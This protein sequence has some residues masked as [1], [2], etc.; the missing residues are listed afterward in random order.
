M[1]PGLLRA[2]SSLTYLAGVLLPFVDARAAELKWKGSFP[3]RMF[4][5]Q[6]K[7]FMMELLAGKITQQV[8]VTE[9]VLSGPEVAA[10]LQN[11][12]VPGPS[13]T[14]RGRS[15]SNSATPAISKKG[16]RISL[17]A[18]LN[19]EDS[20]LK[21]DDIQSSLKRS[22]SMSQSLMRKRSQRSMRLRRKQSSSAFAELSKAAPKTPA[23]Q[24]ELILKAIFV[25]ADEEQ[26]ELLTWDEFSQYL[27]D[28]A[29]TASTQLA[30]QDIQFFVPSKRHRFRVNCGCGTMTANG[31]L[32]TVHQANSSA[33]PEVHISASHSVDVTISQNQVTY[34]IAF[35]LTIPSINV[36]ACSCELAV[37]FLDSRSYREVGRIGLDGLQDTTRVFLW[38]TSKG[39]L[40]AGCRSG[41][42]WEIKPPVWVARQ[43]AWTKPEPTKHWTIGTDS[44]ISMQWGVTADLIFT[45]TSRGVISCFSLESESLLWTAETGPSGMHYCTSM[46][47]NPVTNYLVCGGEAVMLLAFVARNISNQIPMRVEDNVCP[48]ANRVMG[49]ASLEDRPSCVSVDGRGMIKLWDLSSLACTQT[50]RVPMT[51]LDFVSILFPL[52][53]IILVLKKEVVSFQVDG[54]ARTTPCT[55]L[56]TN[57]RGGSVFA[58]MGKDIYEWSTQTLMKLQHLQSVTEFEVLSVAAAE[59][60][61]GTCSS[62]ARMEMSRLTPTPRGRRSRPILG[63]S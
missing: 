8:L 48:H 1:D 3:E 46:V 27:V 28:S 12:K 45:L 54:E 22:G 37:L 44:L 58:V 23:E 61:G 24:A 52:P 47:Y 51:Q 14:D 50:M 38:D 33:T 30:S 2:E 35:A 19:G 6:L 31:R 5:A 4:L 62:F 17:S 21:V 53:R 26:N 13:E 59:V 34:P 32:L 15:N 39:M 7:P 40:Y 43:A 42:L 55:A 20:E 25:A 36:I 10:V 49:L 60:G 63:A 16:S 9:S 41:Q 11:F 56:V 18:M 57:P 29:I